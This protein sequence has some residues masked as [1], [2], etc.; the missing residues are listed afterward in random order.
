MNQKQIEILDRNGVGL[1]IQNLRKILTGLLVLLSI[2]SALFSQ[3]LTTQTNAYLTS[4]PIAIEGLFDDWADVPLSYS[5]PAADNII[6]DFAE[7]KITNDND[8][9]FINFSFHN[10][11]QL[12]QDAN[13]VHL[14]I[15]TDNNVETGFAI[16]DIGA[17]LE[18][19]FGCRSGFF[20]HTTGSDSISQNE[21]TLRRAPTVSAE[22]FEIAISRTC[23]AMTLNGTQRA[24]TVSMLF[25]E[26]DP[27]GDRLPDEGGVQ[28]VID[29][30]FVAPPEPI[31]LARFD[32]RDVRVLTYNV[33]NHKYHVFEDEQM[34]P[35]LERILKALDPDI[36]AFQHVH[37]DSTVDSLIT[38]WF[39]NETWYRMGN[40]GPP[41]VYM[42]SSDKVL[43]S[44]Y[45]ILQYK[46]DFIPIKSMSVCLVDTRQELGANLLLINTHLWAYSQYDYLR[47]QAADEF[48][49]VMREWRAG[50]GPFPLEDNTPYLVLGDFNMYGRGQVLRTLTD[51]DIWDE[52]T[53]GADF[54]P[55]W[56][57]TPITD[58][59]SRHTHIQMGYT[60]RN[61][62]TSFTPGK[63]DY[64]LYS[65]AV[66]DIGNHFILNT[67]AMPE[68]D[69]SRYGLQKEDTKLVSKHLPRILDIVRVHPVGIDEEPRSH[70]P[71]N[72]EVHP[73]YPNPFNSTTKITYYI[74]TSAK[75]TLKIYNITGQE[76]IT[77]VD[78]LQPSG[79][80]SVLWKGRDNRGQI[81]SSGV[82]ICVVQMHDQIQSRKMV[83][84]K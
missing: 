13:E 33:Q 53:Y 49:Q 38:N 65:D 42:P 36:I 29:T 10:G 51:G 27:A 45:P 3:E 41:G 63:L 78:E 83:Y 75:V 64:F 39:P 2:Y 44:K 31:P 25:V 46:I 61:D 60:W 1:K 19:C 6:E 14:Y 7:L 69:L 71:D 26:S 66:M 18:Y 56:D 28:Y 54:A 17:D 4:N 16:H 73:A 24:D 15:D 59:F 11:D 67:L 5:D 84:L 20:H 76:I 34:H 48:I 37:T 12:L 58:L 77:L 62:A 8:F 79:N 32:E 23:D 68:A 81:V 43:F 57:A 9:L 47:Q 82:Y 35:R 52:A 30:A 21:L 80:K 70:L 74:P 72:F 22:R 50:N 40:Y 55:D